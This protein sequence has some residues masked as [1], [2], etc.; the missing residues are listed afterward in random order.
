MLL[1][2]TNEFKDPSKLSTQNHKHIHKKST[3]KTHIHKT[4]FIFQ[5]NQNLKSSSIRTYYY[6][7]HPIVDK[8][9]C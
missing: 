5:S 9:K 1:K 3:T 2:S 4:N 6:Y 7:Y 8:L